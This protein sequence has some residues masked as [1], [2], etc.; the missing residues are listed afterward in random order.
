MAIREGA[1]DCPFC[2][3]RKNRG[4]EKFCGGCGSPRGPEV[5]FYL[6]EDARVVDDASE[7]ERARAGP[8]WTCAFCSGDNKGWNG[9]CTGCG[10]A[11]DAGAARAVVQHAGEAPRSAEEASRPAAPA[12]PPQPPAPP[13]R[14]LWALG[15]LA[16]CGGLFL[17]LLFL[18]G[19]LSCSS[20]Q[21]LE[22]VA[23]HW[24]RNIAVERQV[25]ER[26]QAWSD[27]LPAGARELSR[28]REVRSQRQV[29]IGSQ[30]RTRTVT[31]QVQEGTEQV[32]VGTRDMGN[33][34]FE[35]VYEDRPVYKT[36]Q[37][38]ETYQD[39]VYRQEPVYGT[40]V[41]YEITRWRESRRARASGEDT[42]PQWPATNLAPAERAGP[43]TEKYLLTLKGGNG[44]TYQHEVKEAAVFE[45]FRIG[46]TYP[47]KV[48]RMGHVTELKP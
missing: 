41:T 21:K 24:E 36:V 20:S 31:R 12:P 17:A 22:L 25:A 4:P 3:A 15:C 18:I 10:S 1:W 27:Q 29:Q 16:G 48:N 46:N 30:T 33:G 14:S 43:R 11:R 47:A 45:A 39:P 8:D 32:K 34:Y 13:R 26:E 28:Q 38:E 23:A 19:F 9:F 44:K 35:D 2:G 5:K 40:K 37:E 42:S 7:I 6:P